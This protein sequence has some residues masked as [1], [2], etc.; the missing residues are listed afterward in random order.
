MVLLTAIYLKGD[1]TIEFNEEE[2]E[3]REFYNFFPEHKDNEVLVD[4]MKIIEYFN[5][6]EDSKV[7][8]IELKYK[9]GSMSSVIILHKRNVFIND[10]NDSITEDELFQIISKADLEKVHL[11]L[12][13][14]EINFYD[15]LVDVLN[16]MGI[17]IAF[18]VMLTLKQ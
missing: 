17:K 8:E 11:F 1:W 10:F 13:K 6:Y 12:P 15:N 7:Q 14:F 9:S 4:S 2:T 5:Y 3:K 18:G 16:K